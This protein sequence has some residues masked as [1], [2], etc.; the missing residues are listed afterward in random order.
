MESALTSPAAAA[1]FGIPTIIFSTLIPVV[2]TAIFAY[3]MIRRIRPLVK[4]ASDDRFCCIP[5]RIGLIVKI[6][7]AQWRQPR[8]M[9]AGVLHILIF[10]GFIILGVRSTQLV[11]LGFS[12][13]FVLPG[14]GGVFGQI[15]ST[16]KD[17]AATWVLIACLIAG[18]RRGI[19]KPSRY[20]VPPR[21]GKD[22]TAEAIFV[23]G[24]ISTLM[25]SESVFEASL[26]A[27]QTQ[28]GIHAE[29]PAPLTIAWLFSRMLSGS[30]PA[31]LQNTHLIAYFIHD[32]TFF[33]FLCF[34][35]LG[36]HFH[37]IT[38]L[39]N[40]FFMRIEKGNVKPVRYGISDEQLDGLDSFGV[41]VF[42]DFTWKHILDFYTCAD[43]VQAL[44]A[45]RRQRH[46]SQ[47]LNR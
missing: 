40:V 39:F 32:L 7:L 10:A 17:Y 4:A 13:N 15:Y 18:I 44:S 23:L 29:F 27:A 47:T 36:K 9:L 19:F 3:I 21:Y 24:L 33:F 34:L 5:Q 43:C 2:G 42:E 8:Y 12:E 1:V 46:G 35:P 22:H 38:S 6:W 41:K 37:V 28:K 26:V 11:I 14:F 16:L 25:I 45:G 31:V 30:S 20:A